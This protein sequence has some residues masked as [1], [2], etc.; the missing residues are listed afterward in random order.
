MLRF[1]YSII[2]SMPWSREEFMLAITLSLTLAITTS[3]SLA[4]AM[5]SCAHACCL[6]NVFNFIFEWRTL[7]LLCDNDKSVRDILK[8]RFSHLFN[9]LGIIHKTSLKKIGEFSRHTVTPYSAWSDPPT[10]YILSSCM[11]TLPNEAGT[12]PS[13]GLAFLPFSTCGEPW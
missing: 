2:A 12:E 1:V 6:S 13:L 7:L 4:D 3:T 8:K 9:Y 10:Q 11:K 5:V